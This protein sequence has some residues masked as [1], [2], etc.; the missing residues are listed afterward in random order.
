MRRY[1]LHGGAAV[2]RHSTHGRGP[3]RLGS[4]HNVPG[5]TRPGDSQG[6]FQVQEKRGR[7]SRPI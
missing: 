2:R 4:C 3:L 7:E 5:D 1:L 6:D